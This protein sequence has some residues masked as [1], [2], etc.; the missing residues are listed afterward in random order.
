MDIAKEFGIKITNSHLGHL[1]KGLGYFCGSASGR[2]MIVTDDGFVSGCLEVVDAQDAD[3]EMFR[4]GRFSQKK[5][6]FVIDKTAL[7]RFHGR[8]SDTLN[9]CKNCFARYVCSGGCAIKAV[10]AS[11]NFMK[12]DLPYCVFTKTLIPAIIK[13][14]AVLSKI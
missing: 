9:H 5:D 12:R 8:H 11:G 4:L 2:S 6:T 13:K 1:T 10:R 14:I 7:V 3:F